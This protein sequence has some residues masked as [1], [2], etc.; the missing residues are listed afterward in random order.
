MLQFCTL[1]LNDQIS[2]VMQN[3]R[4][5]P[6]DELQHNGAIL[7][8][9]IYD[10]RMMNRSIHTLMKQSIVTDKLLHAVLMI[11]LQESFHTKYKF[12]TKRGFVLQRNGKNVFICNNI[13]GYDSTQVLVISL[14]EF[15]NGLRI[16]YSYG[17]KV[18]TRWKMLYS[19]FAFGIVCLLMDAANKITFPIL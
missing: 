17:E 2:L 19:G 4:I 1:E 12:D 6:L 14:D 15:E 5:I 8:H 3:T 16:D 11:I 7:A 18:P 13:R 9:A 10:P